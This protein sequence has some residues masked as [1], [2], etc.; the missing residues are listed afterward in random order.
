MFQD[1]WM[2]R[3]LSAQSSRMYGLPPGAPELRGNLYGSF[4]FEYAARAQ[5]L[6]EMLAYM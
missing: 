3:R 4:A 5:A 1:K 2:V 6:L